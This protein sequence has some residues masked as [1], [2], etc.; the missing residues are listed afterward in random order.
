MR[1]TYMQGEMRN[2]QTIV[3]QKLKVRNDFGVLGADRRILLQRV[4]NLNVVDWFKLEQDMV[5][6]QALVRTTM[7]VQIP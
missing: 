1:K 2:S 3:I 7:N 5:Q 6:R 4:L